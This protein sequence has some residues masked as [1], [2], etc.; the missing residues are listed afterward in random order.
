MRDKELN[1]LV[2]LQKNSIV[3]QLI[4]SKYEDIFLTDSK[5]TIG[6]YLDKR[7]CQNSTQR[8]SPSNFCGRQSSHTR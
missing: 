3:C 1:K 4:K 6:K 2:Q 8:N 5:D 7:S